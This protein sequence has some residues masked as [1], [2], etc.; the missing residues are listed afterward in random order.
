MSGGAKL[1]ES[2]H[3]TDRAAIDSP[4]Q[5]SGEFVV[6]RS[7]LIRLAYR[8]QYCEDWPN[9]LV[10]VAALKEAIWQNAE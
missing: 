6:D 5:L 9:P 2:R 4:W 3:G 7:G 10:L 8:Y 1:A